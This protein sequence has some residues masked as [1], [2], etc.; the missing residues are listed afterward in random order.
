MLLYENKYFVEKIEIRKNMLKDLTVHVLEF[1]FSALTVLY[2]VSIA[3][4]VTSWD[5]PCV[6]MGILQFYMKW[7][8][9]SLP[10]HGILLVLS[11]GTPCVVLGYSL[12]CHLIVLVLPWD[13]PYVVIGYFLCCYGILLV[14]CKERL[15]FLINIDRRSVN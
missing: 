8:L 4:L 13:T 15:Q 10:R 3:V 9:Q 7:V 5:T 11:W 12:C 6:V 1:M 14:L 2:E